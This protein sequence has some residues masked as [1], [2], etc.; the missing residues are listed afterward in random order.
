M[1][2]AMRLGT[3]DAKLYFHAG[4]IEWRLGQVDLARQNLNQAL[5]INPYFDLTYP[6]VARKTLALCCVETRELPLS[7]PMRGSEQP[8]DKPDSS[9]PFQ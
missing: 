2:H 5:A 3:K 1:K 8:P 7:L 4:M 6:D 9:T